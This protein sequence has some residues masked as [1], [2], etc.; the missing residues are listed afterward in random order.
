MISKGP[1]VPNNSFNTLCP[2][3]YQ[4]VKHVPR[5]II[6]QALM[7]PNPPQIG[8][9]VDKIPCASFRASQ[10]SPEGKAAFSELISQLVADAE[11]RRVANAEA[12]PPGRPASAYLRQLPARS[13]ELV[14]EFWSNE[15]VSKG[16][17]TL[18]LSLKDPELPAFST[19]FGLSVTS[20]DEIEREFKRTGHA[21]EK[22]IKSPTAPP[23]PRENVTVVLPRGT[24]RYD[25][26]LELLAKSAQVDLVSDYFTHGKPV[27]W[28]GGP[29]RMAQVLADLDQD[30][31][32]T[33]RW[34]GS[35]LLVRTRNWAEAL[36][37]EPTTAVVER[38]ETVAASPDGPELKDVVWIASRCSD[39]QLA[40]LGFHMDPTGKRLKPLELA[41]QI[42]TN[43]AWLRA[44]AALTPAETKLAEGPSGLRLAR[45]PLRTRALWERALMR[46]SVYPPE[47]KELLL[48][49]RYGVGLPLKDWSQM[50]RVLISSPG[51]SAAKD[52]WQAVNLY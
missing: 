8:S 47:G 23:D 17:T 36:E 13:N 33:H 50:P 30:Y 39:E 14:L 9:T 52:L 29:Q 46:A 22:E 38:A 11:A 45:L 15:A 27:K 31:G 51:N 24:Y 18:T 35:T 4:T 2:A 19:D 12:R 41:P 32:L 3:A 10:L 25:R 7:N 5:E 6:Q 49:V 16:G 43:S 1:G 26:A 40:V 42:R 28:E 34:E 21:R 37:R 48:K 44:Y 20:F